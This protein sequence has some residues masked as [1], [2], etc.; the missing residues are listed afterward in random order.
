M[1][2]AE[3]PDLYSRHAAVH[4]TRQMN[5]VVCYIWPNAFRAMFLCGHA[6]STRWL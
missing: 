2:R 3:L 6:R 4:S 1:A 5:A